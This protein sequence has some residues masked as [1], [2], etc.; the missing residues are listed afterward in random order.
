MLTAPQAHLDP[1]WDLAKIYVC[2]AVQTRILWNL[3][4]G[5]VL[6]SKSVMTNVCFGRCISSRPRLLN[7]EVFGRVVLYVADTPLRTGIRS[8]KMPARES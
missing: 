1:V 6:Y 4:I 7:F 8:L 2:Y 5:I 3:H